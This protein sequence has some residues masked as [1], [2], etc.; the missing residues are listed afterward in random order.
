MVL[1]LFGF[2]LISNDI[3]SQLLLILNDILCLVYQSTSIAKT[4]IK[5]EKSKIFLIRLNLKKYKDNGFDT[6]V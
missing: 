6:S 5:V 4:T 3:E 2:K 1:L